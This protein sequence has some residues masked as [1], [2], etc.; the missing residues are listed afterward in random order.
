VEKSQPKA[1][2]TVTSEW[3][4]SPEV[5]KPATNEGCPQFSIFIPAWN[6]A[7]WLP[8]AIE[9]VL[10]QDYDRWE[11]IVSDNASTDEIEEIVKRFSDPR[12]R[13]HRWSTHTD[14]YE[15]FN[16]SVTLCR[17]RWIQPLGIDDRLRPGCLRKMA[18]RA[19]EL[20]KR[21]VRLAAV[22]TASRRIDPQGRLANARFYGANGRRPMCDGLYDASRWLMSETERGWA[23]WIT[24]TV[25]IPREVIAEMGG[26]FRPEIGVCGEI[27]MVLRASAYGDVAYIAEELLD[28]TVTEESD[29]N[30][31]SALDRASGHP[32]PSMAAA[33]LSGL[34]VHQHRR[35]VSEAE[36]K[37]VNR[38]IA[39]AYLRRAAQHRYRPGGRGRLYALRDLSGVVRYDPSRLLS[40]FQILFALTIL[41]APS[42]LVGRLLRNPPRI[43]LL[44]RGLGIAISDSDE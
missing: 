40:P 17:Y 27:E 30:G 34:R 36:R 6:G 32:V 2:E 39:H 41:V 11:L 16:R 22:I 7:K 42:N 1:A 35:Q 12:I 9:S 24:G 44:A 18:E 29:G 37:Q 38:A 5:P 20:E 25:A 28:Y 33:L 14:L 26:L 3:P 13:Y 15:S 21:G 31:R 8:G 43:P 10:N 4:L 19:V 23:P